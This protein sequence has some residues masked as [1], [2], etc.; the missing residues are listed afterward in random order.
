MKPVTN[1]KERALAVMF[2][3]RCPYCGRVIYVDD[4]ACRDCKKK[5]PQTVYPR[6]AVGGF[7]CVSPFLYS[8]AYAD[9]VK[10]FKFAKMIGYARTLSVPVVRAVKERFP[11][12]AF[13]CVAFVPMHPKKLRRERFN[14]AEELARECAALLGLPKVELLEKFKNNKTQHTLKRSRR[15]KNVRGVFRVSDKSLV[16]GKNIL[17]IDDIITTGNTLGECA[18]LLKREGCRSLCCATVCSTSV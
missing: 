15:A 1:F 7:P 10:R 17:L 6:F 12:E 16:K 13:D 2:P 11:G 14:H 8:G 9:A 4:Y 3:V 18:R 5:L